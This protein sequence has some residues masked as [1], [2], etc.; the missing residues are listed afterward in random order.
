MENENN[1][2][3]L[4]EEYLIFLD[5]SGDSKLHE[6]LDIY[7]NPSVYPVF[8]ITALILKRSD[9]DTLLLPKILTL[10]RDFFGDD[11]V[12]LHSN[13]IRRKD[14]AFKV[15]LNNDIYSQFKEKIAKVLDDSNI[16]IVSSSIKKDKL[17]ER[18][19]KFDIVG[20]YNFGN[21]YLRN[22]EFVLERIAHFLNQNS[23]TGKLIFETVGKNESK[24]IQNTLNSLK[25]G[26][27]M[28]HN[29]STFEKIDKEILFYAKKDVVNGLQVADYIVY[30]FAKYAKDF[31]E[32]N[33]LY[34]ILL[35]YIHKNER[36]MYGLKVWP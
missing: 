4:K 9:Y 36:S 15:F 34:K 13:E 30:P 32:D 2:V 12:I 11:T 25:D 27:T 1:I 19:K 16:T 5:E 22:F 26:G 24:K 28:Y 21:I 33:A 10:K 3:N 23:A 6:D 8:T 18:S 17:L 14:R 35:K 7:K 29:S 20:G 31:T